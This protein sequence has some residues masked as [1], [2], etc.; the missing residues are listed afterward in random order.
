M[1][2]L[3]SPHWPFRCSHQSVSNRFATKE[4][5][6]Q[7]HHSDLYSATNQ[8]QVVKYFVKLARKHCMN[9]QK[10]SV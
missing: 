10:H 1:E 3:E 4:D 9:I 7:V 6:L 5:L 2:H 8:Y